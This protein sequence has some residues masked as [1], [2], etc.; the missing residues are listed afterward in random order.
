MEVNCEGCAGCC[1]DWRPLGGAPDHEHGGRYRALDSTYNLV[2]LGRDEVRAFV[3]AGHGDALAPRLFAADDPDRSV[4]LDG[5][6]VAALGDRPLFLVG[7]CKPPKPVAPFGGDRVWLRAC[8]FLDPETLQCRL[9]GDDRYPEACSSYPGHNLDLDR[10][11]ECERV[12]SAHGDPGERLLDRSVPAD[13]PPPAFGPQALG[14]TV[15]VYPDPADLSGVVA[16]LAAGE[17]TADDRALFA[18]AAAGSAPGTTDV[19][20]DRAAEAAERVRAADSWV[21]RA[22]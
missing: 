8:A 6:S 5:H 9:H 17:T 4:E 19:N 1:L 16:R 12:E 15:F 3:D 22:S 11:T 14:S 7:L 2:P 10:E 21:G 20:A 18:G 13:L